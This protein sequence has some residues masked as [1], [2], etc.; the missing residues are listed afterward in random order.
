MGHVLRFDIEGIYRD[1]VNVMQRVSGNVYPGHRPEALQDRVDDFI[2]VSLPNGL[3]DKSVFQRGVVRIEIFCRNR[4]NG[5][6]DVVR[7]QDMLFAI[8]REFPMCFERFSLTD[9]KLMVKGHDG[10]GFSVWN[11]Q[12][13]I[14]VNTTDSYDY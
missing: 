14:M 9:P 7:L 12:C 10:I 8:C 11:V 2:V 4:A 3:D 6:E 13:R 1:I 5:I